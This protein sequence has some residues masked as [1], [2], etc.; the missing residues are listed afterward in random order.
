MVV[1]RKLT[2]PLEVLG[3]DVVVIRASDPV[4]HI[5]GSDQRVV[6]GT[7]HFMEFHRFLP[8][9]VA[10]AFQRPS[11]FDHSAVGVIFRV[12]LIDLVLVAFFKLVGFRPQ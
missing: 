8:P 7:F 3:G 9:L 4:D 2:T 5:P 6:S 1:L 10:L 11:M 12:V